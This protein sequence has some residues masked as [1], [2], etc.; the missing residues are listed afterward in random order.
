MI[1]TLILVGAIVGILPRPWFVAGLVIAAIAW[2]VLLVSSGTVR[3]TDV[4]GML[5]AFALAAVNAAVGAVIT[6]TLVRLVRA[7]RG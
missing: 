7:P 4:E 3:P 2:P 6:R 1:P 5:G